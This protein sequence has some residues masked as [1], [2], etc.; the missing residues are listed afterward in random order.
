L[1]K[2]FDDNE[3]LFIELV[4]TY[5]EEKDIMEMGWRWWRNSIGKDQFWAGQTEIAL[6]SHLFNM[7]LV[8]LKYKERPV[9]K[10]MQREIEFHFSF[11][12]LL[13]IEDTSIDYAHFSRTDNLSETVLLW[14]VDPTNLSNPIDPLGEGKHY[15][16][17]NQSLVDTTK[18][19]SEDILHMEHD[20]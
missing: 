5:F 19:P 10:K 11:P 16:S 20:V 18:L 8:V 7:Q 9:E 3:N 14:V 1:L 13:M 12:S 6:F 15:I 17:L 4:E 2:K